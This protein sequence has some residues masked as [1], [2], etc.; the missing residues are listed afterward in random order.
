MRP[1]VGQDQDGRIAALGSCKLHGH[2]GATLAHAAA[3]QM[4]WECYNM[5]CNT[6]SF[7]TTVR[8]DQFHTLLDTDWHCW[9]AGR[10]SGSHPPCSPSVVFYHRH[11]GC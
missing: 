10:L 3:L 6:P 11:L 8:G 4:R 2:S 5:A 9:E 1:D 7:S